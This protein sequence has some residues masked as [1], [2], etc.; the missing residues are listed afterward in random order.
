[1][2][3]IVKKKVT[4]II[5]HFSNKNHNILNEDLV[6][7]MLNVISSKYY[8]VMQSISS[9]DVPTSFFNLEA[10]LQFKQEACLITLYQCENERKP[11]LPT[12]FK[13]SKH[14][15]RNF[16]SINGIFRNLN[17]E[18]ATIVMRKAIGKE[19]SL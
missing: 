14:H 1:M 15:A 2:E 17:L 7:I 6:D 4:L 12:R 19:S 11:T 3:D 13:H 9:F 16:V 5:N 10:K 8:I 18:L